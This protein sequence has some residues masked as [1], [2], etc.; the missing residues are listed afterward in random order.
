MEFVLE[1]L[2]R[3]D[4][5]SRAEYFKAGRNDGW[6]SS[7]DIRELENMNPIPEELGG[8]DYLI[9]GN[10]VPISQAGKGGAAES[11]PMRGRGLKPPL[12]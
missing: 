6:L 7:N 1:G 3:G 11:P 10:M 12:P 8:D 5:K 4:V 2:L 9:N